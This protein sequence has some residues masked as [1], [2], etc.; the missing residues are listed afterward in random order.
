[1]GLSTVTW[2]RTP[3]ETEFILL[4]VP[5]PLV[6]SEG[7]RDLLAVALTDLLTMLW[8]GEGAVVLGGGSARGWML[9]RDNE[10]PDRESLLSTSTD[11]LMSSK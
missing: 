8:W 5:V 11:L 9:R 3:D 7:R 1:M 4:P 10:L 2:R 6:V